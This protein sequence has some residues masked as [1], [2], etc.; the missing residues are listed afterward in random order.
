[1]AFIESLFRFLL[2]TLCGPTAPSGEQPHGEQPVSYPPQQQHQQHQ[3]TKPYYHND[4]LAHAQD[5]HYV[6]LRKE[7]A[8]ASE[9]MG[10]LFHD[11]REAY[12]RGDGAEASALSKKAKEL[13]NKRDRLHREA[14]DWI[15]EQ[16]NRGRGA[17]EVD[18]H[19][20]R[21]EEAIER[22]D[23]AILD[24]RRKGINELRL[25]VGKGIH[26]QGQHAVLK[27]RI[28]ELMQKHNI[29]AEID[30]QNSGVLIVHLDGHKDRGMNPDEVSKRLGDEDKSCIIM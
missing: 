22:T 20:L 15:F 21:A 7:A 18:L 16:N 23:K 13:R 19:G 3:E 26:S 11:S 6:S 2:N 14:A 12:A 25:I 8:E 9:E 29:V 5:A 24:A 4:Y 1:M 28:E 10:Q 30:P 27:P 17:S